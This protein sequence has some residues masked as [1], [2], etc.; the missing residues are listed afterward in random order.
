[1]APRFW[2]DR[3]A[4]ARM[5]SQFMPAPS[6]SSSRWNRIEVCRMRS[7]SSNTSAPFLIAHGVAEDAFRATGWSSRSPRVRLRL[8]AISSPPVGNAPSV[9]EGMIWGR[10]SWLL[11]EKLARAALEVAINFSRPGASPRKGAILSS[12]AK[13]RGP[14]TPTVLLVDRIVASALCKK[15]CGRGLWARGAR[16]GACHRARSGA[17]P[18]AW[19]GR[20]LPI[21]ESQILR[22]GPLPNRD[23]AR[24]GAL[25]ILPESSRGR[26]F[27]DFR[28]AWAPL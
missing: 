5:I 11:P 18:L 24:A 14:T 28:R 6:L 1:M 17:D 25:K 26:C 21:Y 12:P 15:K 27:E 16:G 13:K 7:T 4:R 2:L 20:R 10:H 9:S 22:P 23:R 19:P 8:A 3:H